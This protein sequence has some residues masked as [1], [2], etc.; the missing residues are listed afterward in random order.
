MT[1]DKIIRAAAEAIAVYRGSRRSQS[2]WIEAEA[3]VAFVEPL[4]REQTLR[5][6]ADY[7]ES[8]MREGVASDLRQ[9]ADEERDER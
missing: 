8:V 2:A 6:A 9:M 3:I 5:D 4:I 7:Y 1:D